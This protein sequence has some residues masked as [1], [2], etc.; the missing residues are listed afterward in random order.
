MAV[1][2]GA[3]VLVSEPALY[4]GVAPFQAQDSF[5]PQTQFPQC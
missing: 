5:A 2:F 4:R 3:G 1:Q